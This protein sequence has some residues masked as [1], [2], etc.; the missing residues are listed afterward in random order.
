MPR[1]R[2]IDLTRTYLPTGVAFAL[3]AVSIGWFSA[4]QRDIQGVRDLQRETLYELRGTQSLM[5]QWVDGLRQ[6]N[7]DL[8]IPH[9]AVPSGGGR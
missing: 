9:L 3:I 5:G 4:I 7:P 6:A 2:L 8:R 1:D